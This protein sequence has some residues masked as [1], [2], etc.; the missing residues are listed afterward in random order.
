MNK[1]AFISPTFAILALLVLAAL[2]LLTY[3]SNFQRRFARVTELHPRK[4]R[5]ILLAVAAMCFLLIN[6]IMHAILIGAGV[7]LY[8]YLI[9]EDG[10]GITSLKRK[11]F[12]QIELICTPVEQKSETDSVPALRKCLFASSYIVPA[13]ALQILTENGMYKV[14]VTLFS[15]Q[16]LNSLIYFLRESGFN[17]VS[18]TQK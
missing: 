5:S 17:T 18:N 16:Y 6:P 2:F 7:L 14:K 9:R 1:T 4:Q 12:F 13:S 15:E 10:K 3:S 8:R 11:S